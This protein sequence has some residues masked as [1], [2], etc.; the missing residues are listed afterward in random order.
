MR[1]YNLIYP[2]YLILDMEN[3]TCFKC[4][5]CGMVGELLPNGDPNWNHCD[6]PDDLECRS[7]VRMTDEGFFRYHQGDGIDCECDFCEKFR[8]ENY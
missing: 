6:C 1:V 5:E 4:E 7:F 2:P 8:R 3:Q